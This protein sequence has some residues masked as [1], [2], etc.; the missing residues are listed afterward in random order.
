[1]GSGMGAINGRANIGL[2]GEAW[3]GKTMWPFSRKNGTYFAGGKPGG[4]RDGVMENALRWSGTQTRNGS[5]GGEEFHCINHRQP[6]TAEPFA[7]QTSPPP[8]SLLP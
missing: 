4:G 2:R 5:Y 3:I 1:M 6:I 8:S 7:R